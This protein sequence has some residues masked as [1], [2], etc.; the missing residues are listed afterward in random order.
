MT[1]DEKYH[2][3]WLQNCRDIDKIIKDE[4]NGKPNPMRY[5][6]KQLYSMRDESF[7]KVEETTV[8]HILALHRLKKE[9][10]LCTTYAK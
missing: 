2:E 10:N 9:L 7:R 3:G 1:T 4:K 8:D 5:T 6:L